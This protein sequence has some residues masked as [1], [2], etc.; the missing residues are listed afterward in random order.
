MSTLR[1]EYQNTLLGF[2]LDSK[3]LQVQTNLRRSKVDFYDPFSVTI[4][5]ISNIN[6]SRTLPF[7]PRGV[8][9]L[10]VSL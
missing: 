8:N 3:I 2:H 5:T 7:D 10:I 4:V 6:I 9:G 1:Q